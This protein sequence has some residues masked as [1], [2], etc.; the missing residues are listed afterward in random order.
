MSRAERGKKVS[1]FFSPVMESVRIFSERKSLQAWNKRI[2]EN[3]VLFVERGN[4]VAPRGQDNV[5]PPTCAP[6]CKC[7]NRETRKDKNKGRK[8]KRQSG[9]ARPRRRRERGQKKE[10][11]VK[12]KGKRENMCA[13]FAF[14][15][16]GRRTRGEK[17]ER[18]MPAFR[19][20]GEKDRVFSRCAVVFFSSDLLFF[21]VKI[22]AKEQ[23]FPVFC[24]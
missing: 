16:T 21:C 7:R 20:A 24:E 9:G 15:R 22:Y 23:F 11:K 14:R 17:S 13:S 10:K 8:G 6:K 1:P 2:F 5:A 4:F 12:G 19:R 18:G 3:G